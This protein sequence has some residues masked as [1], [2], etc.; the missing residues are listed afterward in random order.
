MFFCHDADE[1]RRAWA[2]CHRFGAPIVQELIPGDTQAMRTVVLLFDRRTQLVAHF[3]T[4]KLEQYPGSGGVTAMSVSTDEPTLV[5]AVLPFFETLRWQGPAEVELKVDARDGKAK[6]IEVN[7]RLPG[8]VAFPIACGLPLPRLAAL[9]ALGESPSAPA[10]AVGQRYVQP[11]LVLKSLVQ[12]WRAGEVTAGRLRRDFPALLTAPWVR[13]DDLVDPRPRLAR[14]L[15]E[16][17]GVDGGL[18]TDDGLR[19]A[20]LE[21]TRPSRP[22]RA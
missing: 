11:M 13:W 4:R 21:A 6:V 9:V 2:V 20:E 15:A 5:E 1:L 7:P 22:R 14:A 10:Y 18:A 8:Y 17:R 3:T 12:A 16:A 19:L